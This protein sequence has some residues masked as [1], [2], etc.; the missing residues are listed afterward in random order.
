[1]GEIELGGVGSIAGCPRVDTRPP[2]RPARRGIS[3]EAVLPAR[4][5]AILEV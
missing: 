2:S 3:T 4:A 5:I 1:V